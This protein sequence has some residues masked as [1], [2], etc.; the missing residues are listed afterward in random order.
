MIE[1]S[2]LLRRA[3]TPPSFDESRMHREGLVS[4]IVSALDHK[5]IVVV[6]P[7]GYGKTTLMADF[8]THTDLPVC[9]VG[10]S[11]EDQDPMRLALVLKASLQRRFRRLRNKLDLKPLSGS[12][13]EALARTLVGAIEEHI[14]ERFIIA[15]DDVHLIN[16]S[17]DAIKLIDTLILESPDRLTILAAGRVLPEVSI[18][19]LIVN[20]QM[21]GIGTEA[22]ALSRDEV[23]ALVE[24]NLNLDLERD[25]ADLLL[26]QT[27]GWIPGVL[28]SAR[29]IESR[30]DDFLRGRPL[31]HEFLMTSAFQ[32]EPSDLREF[33]LEAAVL[34]I[35]TSAACDEVL[36][37]DDSRKM[38]G[39]LA[40]KGLFISTTDLSPKTYEF[41]ALYRNFLV[42]TLTEI[43][44]E[45]HSR[46]SV[47]AAEYFISSDD[48]ELAISLFT[49]AGKSKEATSLAEKHA[50]EMFELGRI[51]TL[52][53]WAHNLRDS[54]D[55]IPD[56]HLYLAT[57]NAD[58]GNLEAA[59]VGLAQAFS[60]LESVSSNKRRKMLA[61]AETVRGWIAY[62]KGEYRQVFEAVD[63]AEQLLPKRGSLLRRATCYRLRALATHA[64]GGDLSLA[65]NYALKSVKL[66]EKTDEDFTLANVLLDLSR[67]R[68]NLG[69]HHEGFAFG[70]RAYMILNRIGSPNSLAICLN[71]LAVFRH[72]EG[73][74]EEALEFFREGLQKAHQAANRSI[75]ATLLYG[76]ADLF[77]DL[78]LSHQA[79]E[80]YGRGLTIATQIE[81]RQLIFY[82]FLGT[83]VLHRRWGTSVSSL[84]WLRRAEDAAKNEGQSTLAILQR[85]AIEL[86]E[87]PHKAEVELL[88]LL[89]R[90]ERWLNASDQALLLYLLS[91]AL[92]AQG[93]TTAG[94]DRFKQ[95]LD[96]AGVN[97]M[98]RVLAAEMLADQ[99]ALTITSQYQIPHPVLTGVLH[100][101]EVMR[102]FAR[103]LQ[104]KGDEHNDEH[105]LN[106]RSLGATEISVDGRRVIDIEP[107]PRQVLFYVA[108]KGPISRDILLEDIWPG[109]TIDSA[110]SSLYNATH[111]LRTVIMDDLIFIDGSRYQINQEISVKYDISEFEQAAEIAE[112]MA[113]GDPQ[114]F[115]ALGEALNAYRGSFLSE[116]TADWVLV[117]RSELER[118]YL[119]LLNEH[120]S[121]ALALGKEE[122]ALGSLRKAI[123]LDPLRDDLNMRYLELLSQMGRRSKAVSH[124]QSYCRLLADELGLDPPLE[125][126]DLYDR[127][128]G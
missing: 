21:F 50:R 9:W 58:I 27:Q 64:S 62:R 23:V 120:A 83:S 112:A 67:F 117:R 126:R 80:L 97:S 56:V 106:L 119:N 17:E 102:A 89:E 69:G 92:V 100:R 57:A 107:L 94:S 42:D 53:N 115:F 10:L 16:A 1:N 95:A 91:M 39:R 55:E 46:L 24:K 111:R 65:E 122:S 72:L 15:L 81:Q 12:P 49:L 68:S 43:D 74:F 41:H 4:R 19:K 33:M 108:D 38:L 99:N 103:D 7:P 3:I 37:R 127:I 26:D 84:A 109:T 60:A 113:S 128:I 98:E 76:Q 14:S 29:S 96:S 118:R 77:C 61:R 11:E 35:M 110:L 2:S 28:L 105:P 104:R 88:V 114:R 63:R 85:A 70:M 8:I 125:V 71:N 30:E 25:Q 93:K 124:Y 101:I 34:P 54:S 40:R 22:L 20:A 47:R 87:D 116:F 52:S 79:G 73:H 78:G 31:L 13:P 5:L 123:S 121:E 66:L 51:I 82:G 18:S 59:E 48:I 75:Q 44:P 90:G 6:A 36:E 45:R 32:D 86:K